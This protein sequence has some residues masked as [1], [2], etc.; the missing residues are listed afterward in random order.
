MKKKLS[1]RGFI[2]PERVYGNLQSGR[3]SER[4]FLYALDKLTA[5]TS[6]IYFH[7][8]LYPDDRLL[9]SDQRQCLIEFEALTSKRVKERIEALGI[10][11]TNYF[12][13]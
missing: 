11:L 2:F 10:R 5:A 4:Y 9:D 7:P 13:L 6:E 12:E 3:M 8:G 1:A